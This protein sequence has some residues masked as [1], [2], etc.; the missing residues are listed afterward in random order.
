[1]SAFIRFETRYRCDGSA[2]PLGVF[3]TAGKVAERT[4]LDKWTRD[5]LVDRTEWF[6][7][8]LPAPRQANLD[9]K[10]VFWFCPQ[11]EMVHEVWDLVAA[12]REIGVT[13]E[14]RWTQ[15][16]GK[17]VYED[18]FQIAAIPFFR[19]RARSPRRFV[20]CL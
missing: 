7:E 16:P 3:R 9:C 5:W 2:R 17:I 11:T 10:A 12:L 4:D 8:H 18:E 1:M 19:C 13:V 15:M 20:A 14:Q 6:N